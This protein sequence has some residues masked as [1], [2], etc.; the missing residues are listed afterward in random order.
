MP[1]IQP[2]AKSQ[3]RES[4]KNAEGH[5]GSIDDQQVRLSQT[6]NR[7]RGVKKNFFTSSV[8]GNPK[9][10]GKITI[11]SS[12]VNQSPPMRSVT[13]NQ[14]GARQAPHTSQMQYRNQNQSRQNRRNLNYASGSYS[15]NQR[16]SFFTNNDSYQESQVIPIAQQDSIESVLQMCKE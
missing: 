13:S 2:Y 8:S 5:S 1:P 10:S 12:G 3:S 14:Q 6:R 7:N 9:T 16:Q 11:L 15:V 4:F